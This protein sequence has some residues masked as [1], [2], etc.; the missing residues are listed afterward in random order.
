MKLSIHTNWHSG[1]VS[2]RLENGSEYVVFQVPL[3]VHELYRA[4]RLDGTVMAR[5]ADQTAKQ[6]GA[7]LSALGFDLFA[8]E[9][10][11]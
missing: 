11:T 8:I 10:K 4:G 2:V 7:L 9:H 3:E 6:V 5:H 1:R